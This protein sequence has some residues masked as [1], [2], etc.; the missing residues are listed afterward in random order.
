MRAHPGRTTLPLLLAAAC[1]LARGGAAGAAEPA[2]LLRPPAVP[3]VACDPYF[4]IW[5]DADKLTDDATRHWTGKKQPLT[6]MIRIDG[7]AY[8]LMGDE[9]KDVPALRQKSVFVKPTSTLYF[10][11][12]ANV[13][14]SLTFMTPTFPDDLDVLSR[15]VTYLWWGVFSEDGQP[16]GASLYFAAGAELAVNVP[17]QEVTWSRS[18][19]GDL[20]ALRVGSATQPVLQA[21][22]DDLRIDWGHAYIAAKSDAAKGAIGSAAALASAF[23]DSGKLPAEDDPRQPRAV[24][25]DPPALAFA[26][27]LG[28]VVKGS[29]GGN[30]GRVLIAYDDEYSITYFRRKL[31]PYWRRDGATAD[32]LLK[33]ADA[34]FQAL[35]NRS[36]EFDAELMKDLEAAGGKEYARLAALSYRQAFAANKLVADANGKP[37]LFPKE[38]FSNGCIATV[39]VIYP[40]DPLFLLFSPTLAKASLVPVLAYSAS[41]R[42]KFPFAPH[43][44]GT[45]PLANGQVYGGG[46]RTEVDQM[47]VEETGNMLLLLAAIAQEEDSAE[48][49]SA[50]WP[51]LKKW[52]AYLEAKG[53]DPENQLCTD[54]FAG[55][56]AH[57]VNLSA[58]AILALGA[59]GQLCERRG[60]KAEGDRYHK[61]AA[62]MAQRWVKEADDGDHFRLAFDRPGTWS[63]KYNLVWD[64]LLGLDIFP[65][66]A[67][68]K[69]FAF[70]RRHMDKY[71]LPLDNRQPYAKVDWTVWTATL[72]ADRAG[73]E[74]LVKPVYE[75][76]NDSPS[77]VPL[78]DWYFT[79]DAK[80]VGFQARS[81][82]GGVFIRL[83]DDPATWKKWA[84]R[85]KVKVPAS[86]W[87]PLPP[88]PVIEG[89]VPTAESGP[90]AWRVTTGS[91]EG[92]WTKPGYDD[93]RWKKAPG[94]F[95]SPDT[96]G[97]APHLRTEWRTPDIWL[98]REFTLP[99]GGRPGLQLRAFHDEDAEVY[100]NGVPA[101]K[102]SGYATEYDLLPISDAARAALKPGKN[103]LAVHCHQ[104]RGGQ[105]IDVG[106]VDVREGR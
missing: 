102:V 73:F 5:S 90:V 30:Y 94:G 22:G 48:F 9:P 92:D 19:V 49:A 11:T 86:A 16:H 89:V 78:T 47:P 53:F 64:K 42:W 54:D 35:A 95:G 10:F 69:E 13:T 99:G 82:V 2:K 21:K 45:Y 18:T 44:L 71:G 28:K 34:E 6:S 41:D 51:Q 105:Y 88:A 1:I 93:S 58:K 7:K 79:K 91:P 43:D 85:D 39:D 70:Y 100:L 76:M 72:A 12:G 81:V 104:T 25:D 26:F 46:E 32:D 40:M 65:D 24:K 63:Q 68:Q 52:A 29:R 84:G 33:K 50:Y 57:N 62:E 77:R 98:R 60:E 83:M 75:A 17:E 15:P 61:L 8:R 20:T 74:A 3:L 80:Q 106:I 101:A 38:N 37:L 55:H 14:V 56:L 31:R 59:Y 27:D 87:A 23:V 4:S 103:V 97:T 67:I 36:F 96:P 66:D